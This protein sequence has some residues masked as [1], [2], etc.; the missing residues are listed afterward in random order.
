MTCVDLRIGGTGAGNPPM[1][2]PSFNLCTTFNALGTNVLSGKGRSADG[3]RGTGNDLCALATLSG[4]GIDMGLDEGRRDS[5]FGTT[6]STGACRDVCFVGA[7][8]R[9]DNRSSVDVGGGIGGCF[10]TGVFFA[11]AYRFV[12]TLLTTNGLELAII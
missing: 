1:S 3:T 5:V 7:P 2:L 11:G 4:T 10:F 12:E 9:T 6:D 8:R